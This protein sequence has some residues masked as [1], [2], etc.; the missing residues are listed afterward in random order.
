MMTY[1]LVLVMY[2]HLFVSRN[3]WLTRIGTM[4]AQ[5]KGVYRLPYSVL[6]ARSRPDRLSFT[7][8]ELLIVVCQ[9]FCLVV[10]VQSGL[11]Q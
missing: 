5:V 3:P 8:C 6:C 10:C 9:A 7:A 1:C 2:A 4:S 11:S